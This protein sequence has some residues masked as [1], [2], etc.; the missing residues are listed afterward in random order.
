MQWTIPP[1]IKTTLHLGFLFTLAP[2]ISCINI[3]PSQ[4]QP[5]T[6]AN[7][8][9]GT[10]VTPNGNQIDITGGQRSTNGANLFHS[11]Q[12]FGL[13]ANQI[14]N[15]LSNPNIQNILGRVVGGEASVIKGLIQVTGGNSNLYL[16]NPA[17][18]VF[19]STARLNVPAS[20]T[21]TTAT[22]IGIGCGVSGGGCGNWFNA[23]GTNNYATL[24]GTPDSFAF[25]QAQPGAII[26]TGNLSVSAGDLTL[27]GGTVISTGE[28]SAPAGEITIA[29]VPGENLV[30]IS[31]HGSLL[32][33]EISPFSPAAPLSLTPLSLPQLLTGGNIGNATGLTTNA[34]GQVELVGSGITVEAGDVVARRI[35]T[36]TGLLSANQNLTLVESQLQTTGNLSLLARNTVRVRDSVATPVS[37]TAGSNLTVQGNQSI[38][39]LALNHST[40]A[41]QS[42][43]NLTLI[44][45]GV[46]SGDA[47][48]RSGGNFSLLTLAGNPGN[49]ISLYDPIISSLGDVNF[50]NYTGVSLKVEAI[51]SITGG[52]ININGAD[53]GLTGTDPDIPILTGGAALILRAG[54]PTLRNPPNVPQTTGGTTFA[55]PPSTATIPGSINIGN[56]DIEPPQGNFGPVILEAPGTIDTGN[57]DTSSARGV[58]SGAVDLRAGGNV[59]TGF[60]N[61]VSDGRVPGNSGAVTITSENGSITTG[62]IIT[63]KGGLPQAQP[64][65]PPPQRQPGNGGAIVLNAAQDITIDGDVDSGGGGQG[66]AGSVSLTS[67]G[68]AIRINNGLFARSDD[69][70]GGTV[71]LNAQ[72]DIIINQVQTVATQDSGDITI[73]SNTGNIISDDLSSNGTNNGGAISLTA[74]NGNINPGAITLGSPSN[75]GGDLTV[76]SPNIDLFDGIDAGGANLVLGNQTNPNTI[77]L[78][79]NIDTGGG[80]FAL[81]LNSSNLFNFSSTITTAGGNFTLTNSGALTVSGAVQTSGGNINL[82]GATLT[83]GDLNT[84]VAT[85]GGTIALTAT[86]G[87][88]NAGNLTTVGTSGT[89]GTIDLT[90]RSGLVNSGNLTTTGATGGGQVTVV[91]R[92]SIAAGVIDSSSTGGNGGNVSLD[93]IGNVQ[94]NSINTQGGNNG[95][96]VNIVAGQ[97]F[98][99][100][101]SF[102]NQNGITASI[103]SAGGNQGG[104]ITIR[105]GGGLQNIPFTVGS[106]ATN[107]TAAAITSGNTNSILPTQS[108]PGVFTQGNIQIITQVLPP[109]PDPVPSPDPAP[110]PLQGPPQA[111][112]VSPLPFEESPFPGVDL[113]QSVE[114][115]EQ[116]FTDEFEVLTGRTDT[117]IKTLEEIRKELAQIEQIGVKPALIYVF[118][119]PEFLP[120]LS[121]SDRALEPQAAVR[122]AQQDTDHLALILVTS[123]GRI[124]GRRV[125]KTRRSQVLKTVR[126]FSNAVKDPQS[127]TQYLPEAQQL[128]QWLVTPLKKDLETAKVTNLVYIMDAG[129]RS[130]PLAVLHDGQ[131]FILEEYSVGLMPSMSLTDARYVDVKQTQALAMGASQF[132]SVAGLPSENNLPTVP[133][134]LTAIANQLW[135]GNAF[136]NEDF[137]LAEL[138][139]QR[140]EKRFGIVHLATHAEFD[141]EFPN[142]SYIRLW[143]ENVDFNKLRELNLNK[144]PI[145]LLVLSACRTAV[146]V[147]TVELGFAGLSVQIGV[148]SSLASL[149]YVDDEATFVLMSKFYRQLGQS[150]IKADGLRLAQLEMQKRQNSELTELL[151]ALQQQQIKIPPTLKQLDQKDFSHPY[152]WAGFTIV[153]NPW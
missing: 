72:N 91:A 142:K 98:Q 121:N 42:G 131:R 114:G 5:I 67:T 93:P 64:G 82:S 90:A 62:R 104:A 31:Q 3:Q 27:L 1:A 137:T 2:I 145:E 28:L 130:L 26:N 117:R 99:A 128:Y 32:S 35:T 129:L 48:Y 71:E 126:A 58:D 10:I 17:G 109:P 116:R 141:P 120:A 37:I 136:L 40:P 4:A 153:G 103:S 123:D 63:F 50:G 150:V 89:G 88:L 23:I 38:D 152:Y 97:F 81:N 102:T 61:T 134:E 135:Q 8:G 36:E 95:G 43:G 18:I 53:V 140:D 92:D 76:N 115:L 24:I 106:S 78:P 149:W 16:M 146:G 111:A 9:T 70:N 100:S 144:P 77:L 39:I 138:N 74:P 112:P 7:D 107:G 101:G 21:A 139:A 45:D 47:H 83:T 132:P 151:T 12:Q 122:S 73:T 125:P 143:D 56:I 13:D 20:F 49:F 30:R 22:G 75:T 57:I 66:D 46:I 33:L 119:V 25:A 147:L 54:V 84:S 105:H 51:G 133:L 110:L 94:V 15:F 118:F 80:D 113:D 108:F 14:A 59:T 79:A 148:K 85:N 41:F 124:I 127:G 52:N 55:S 87:N 68:G 6:P 29:A 65:A 34:N 44:S 60:I 96:S 86:N 69:G 11:F 19:G